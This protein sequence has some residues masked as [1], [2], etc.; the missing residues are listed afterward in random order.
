M[1]HAYFFGPSLATLPCQFSK[2][3]IT[4]NTYFPLY[5]R[6]T[7]FEFKFMFYGTLI[8]TIQPYEASL[9]L[10]RTLYPLWNYYT[11]SF[12]L[13]LPIAILHTVPVDFTSLMC[14]RC[15]QGL[16]FGWDEKSSVARAPCSLTIVTHLNQGVT[17]WNGFKSWFAPERPQDFSA[18]LYMK[19]WRSYTYRRCLH[20]FSNL[21][22]TWPLRWQSTITPARVC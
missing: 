2:Y 4:P 14:T 15:P 12:C 7:S 5:W 21:S 17:W 9:I 13:C 3:P 6:L 8:S 11:A 18:I 19:D 1:A 22:S 20:L 16:V 10:H